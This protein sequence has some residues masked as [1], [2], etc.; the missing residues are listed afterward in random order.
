[1]RRILLVITCLTLSS[2]ASQNLLT[3]G[4][5]TGNDYI[6]ASGLIALSAPPEWHWSTNIPSRYLS[7]IAS[8][9]KRPREIILLTKSN[10]ET[11]ILIETYKLTWGGRYITPAVLTS[12]I[13]Q[14]R[15]EDACYFFMKLEESSTFTSYDYKC[16]PHEKN[17]KCHFDTPC[18]ESS[19]ER[20]S[21]RTN[22]GM[23]YD[24]VYMVGIPSQ[25]IPSGDE[26]GWR[27][28]YTLSTPQETAK[29]NKIA[30]DS[31]VNSM[32]LVNNF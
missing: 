26:Q 7:K 24:R 30:L 21:T 4:S 25:L 18:L 3:N 11:S 29:E 20:M 19:R 17:S 5:V 6:S 28:S 22:K 10:S 14:E 15:R 16:F 2:C 31:V 1:M 32:R 12:T 8:K 27:I 13:S 9:L 23:I